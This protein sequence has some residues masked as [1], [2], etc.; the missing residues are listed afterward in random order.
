MDYAKEVGDTL[1]ENV[2]K[3]MKHIAD[4][5][6]HWSQNNLDPQEKEM[7]ILVRKNSMRLLY[8]LLFLLFA[9]GSYS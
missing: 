5:F 9:E 2:Y 4:G 7:R 1:K 3:A 6:F 8:R